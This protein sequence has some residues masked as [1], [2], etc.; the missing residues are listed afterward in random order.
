MSRIFTALAV[1]S[2]LL[3]CT[4]L[5]F[6]LW[7]GRYNENY[8]A[9]LE[10]ERR[11]STLPGDDTQRAQ[12]HEEREALYAQMEKP[13]QRA[14]IHMLL[15]ILAGLVAILV[16]CISVTYFIGTGRWCKEVADTYDLDP[17]FSQRSNQL[18]R[19]TFAWALSGMLTVL[20]IV[21]LGGASDPGT[22][23]ET[24]PQWVTPHLYAAWFGATWIAISF[25]LQMVNIR[26]NS[27]II[28]EVVQRV[29]QIRVER[30]LDVAE[31]ST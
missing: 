13:Q 27:E 22:L 10:V 9:Y 31:S 19:R 14:R 29:H 24:T 20:L 5:G 21:G 26:L 2:T 23:R 12:L 1:F 6:G 3:L 7:I 28:D 11:M 15:G 30:G 18:K 4:A 16:N 25:M 17:T 8:A